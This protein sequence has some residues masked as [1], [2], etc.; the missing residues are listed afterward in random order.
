MMNIRGIP[1]DQLTP[2]TV[3]GRFYQD[4]EGLDANPYPKGSREYEQYMLEM[5]RLQHDEFAAEFRGQ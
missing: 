2:K 5:A 3:A 4:G 1:I